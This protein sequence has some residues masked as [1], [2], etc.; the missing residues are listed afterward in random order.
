MSARPENTA[1]GLLRDMLFDPIVSCNT[2]GA[3]AWYRLKS[4]RRV[5]LNKAEFERLERMIGSGRYRLRF[6]DKEKGAGQ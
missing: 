4:G 6:A 1:V 2:E 5:R 3:G